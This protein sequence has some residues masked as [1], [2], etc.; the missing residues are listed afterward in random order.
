MKDKIKKIFNSAKENV[1][2][3]KAAYLFGAL[4]ISAIGLQQRSR[5]EFDR[6]LDEKGIDRD[7]YYNPEY[8]EEKN[9]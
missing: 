7:E 9:S 3:N 6:F 8:F 5:Q 1:K 2:N 4:A